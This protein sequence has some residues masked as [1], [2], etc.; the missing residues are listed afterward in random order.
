MF[1][2]SS[3]KKFT[4]LNKKDFQP[5]LLKILQSFLQIFNFISC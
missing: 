5:I 3:L 4:D 1:F 2:Q